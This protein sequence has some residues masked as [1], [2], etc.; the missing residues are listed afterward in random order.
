MD[1]GK[2]KLEIKEN[3]I[4]DILDTR[5]LRGWF[6]DFTSQ[7]NS[8]GY[9]QQYQQFKVTSKAVTHLSQDPNLDY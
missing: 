9:E 6:R 5:N 2:K 1:K 8:T 3:W 7:T 4:K